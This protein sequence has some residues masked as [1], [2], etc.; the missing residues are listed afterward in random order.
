MIFDIQEDISGNWG[1]WSELTKCSL[2]CSGGVQTRSRVCTGEEGCP[3]SS[4][5]TL[6]CNT[7]ECIGNFYNMTDFIF[8]TYVL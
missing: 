8:V 6:A 1:E 5:E 2:A 4:S 3:G 7:E